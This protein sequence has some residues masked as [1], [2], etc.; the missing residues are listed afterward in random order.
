MKALTDFIVHQTHAGNADPKK[1][2]L[3]WSWKQLQIIKLQVGQLFLL[4]CRRTAIS[5]FAK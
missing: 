5:S 1:A 4:K 3:T 2:S